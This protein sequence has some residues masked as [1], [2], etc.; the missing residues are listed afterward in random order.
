MDSTLETSRA[1]DLRR[2]RALARL[3][4]SAIGIPGTSIRIGLDPIIGLVPGAGDVITASMSA[5][6]IVV[7]ARAGAP[8]PVLVRMVANILVDTGLGAVPIVG[9]LFDVAFKSNV[10]NLRLLERHATEPATVTKSNRGLGIALAAVVVI[11]VLGIAT[12]GFFAARALWH[13]LAR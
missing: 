9:D 10:K 8:A 1:T 7:A 12:A 4:D 13:L 3:L 5:Y 6:L 11:L 2:A